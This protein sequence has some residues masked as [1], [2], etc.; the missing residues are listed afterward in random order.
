MERKG[1]I[2]KETNY[3]LQLIRKEMFR[4]TSINKIS[5][6]LKPPIRVPRSSLE[7][8]R[9]NILEAV[10]FLYTSHRPYIKLTNLYLL[11]AQRVDST[12]LEEIWNT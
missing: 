3:I 6:W 10:H 7:T 11:N 2:G 5:D 4:P 8:K 12:V 9:R 1:A